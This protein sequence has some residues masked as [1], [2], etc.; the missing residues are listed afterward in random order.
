VLLEG[1]DFCMGVLVVVVRSLD[2]IVLVQV[3]GFMHIS[4]Y[5]WGQVVFGRC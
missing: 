5:R 1:L 4:F 2:T 3:Y